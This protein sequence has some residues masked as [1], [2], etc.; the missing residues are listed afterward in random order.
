MEAAAS[1]GMFDVRVK[2]NPDYAGR[3]LRRAH[4][5]ADRLVRD[6]PDSPHAG[7]A[8]AWRDLVR[9]Y[10]VRGRELDRRTLELERI[11]LELERRTRELQRHVRELERLKQLDLDLEQRKRK[12]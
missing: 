7:G 11:S 4:L 6:Y 10:L 8:R 12:P 9:A 3:D 2:L 1:D 5:V